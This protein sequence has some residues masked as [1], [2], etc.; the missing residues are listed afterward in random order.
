MTSIEFFM[1][2]YHEHLTDLKKELDNKIEAIREKTDTQ[3]TK[4]YFQESLQEIEQL[5]K[6]F[7]E[8]LKGLKKQY[9]QELQELKKNEDSQNI[10]KLTH[11]I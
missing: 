5:M 10:V 3:L 8:N 2:Q 4:E 1:L 9:L 6:E 7:Q 11:D